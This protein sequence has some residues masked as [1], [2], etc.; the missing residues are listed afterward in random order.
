MT[1]ARG[2]RAQLLEA[3]EQGRS[4][5]A[6]LLA[7]AGPQRMQE[8]GVMGDWTL[9]DV[10]AHLTGWRMRTVARLEAAARGGEPVMPW[11]AELGNDDG[12]GGYE[13]INQWLYQ[14]NRA[15]PT[16]EVL[17]ESDESFSKLAAAI[18]ALPDAVLETPGRFDW[19][20]GEALGPALIGGMNEHLR[21]EH[22]PGIRAWLAR[23]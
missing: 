8:P 14:H 1:D 3:V 11:P 4:D 20:G 10:V 17:R 23:G 9:H 6:A 18:E 15:R 19:L 13:P 12:D 7:E 22:E 5:L 2:T 16:S 21:E